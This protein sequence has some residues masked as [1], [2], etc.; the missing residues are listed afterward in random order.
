MGIVNYLKAV[1]E[2]I[3]AATFIV[4]ELLAIGMIVA[5][6]IA[7][8]ALPEWLPT[9]LAL[10]A[11]TLGNYLINLLLVVVGKTAAVIKTSD[12][13]TSDV[14]KLRDKVNQS[15]Y[16]N[17]LKEFANNSPFTGTLG[18]LY[19]LAEPGTRTIYGITKKEYLSLLRQALHDCKRSY[20]TV[21]RKGG[22][23][24]FNEDEN[25]LTEFKNKQLLTKQRILVAESMRVISKA[26]ASDAPLRYYWHAVGKD[27]NTHWITKHHLGELEI[28]APASQHGV[29][30][31]I[32]NGCDI[33]VCDD[34]L[35]IQY[36]E[37]QHKLEFVHSVHDMGIIEPYGWIFDGPSRYPTKFKL[38]MQPP[39]G[40]PSYLEFRNAKGIQILPDL[41]R[42]NVELVEGKILS[43]PR[44]IMA[45]LKCDAYGLGIDAVFDALRDAGVRWFGVSRVE[46]G[47]QILRLKQIREGRPN[48]VAEPLRIVL[49]EGIRDYETTE[50][51]RLG[52]EPFVWTEGDIHRLAMSARAIGRPARVHMKL[53][54]GMRV[55][56][57]NS[58][59]PNLVSAEVQDFVS[60]LH[61]H[62]PHVQ[63]AGVATQLRDGADQTVVDSQ[64][65]A[66]VT[67]LN[68]IKSA[69]PN[70]LESAWDEDAIETNIVLHLRNT[71]AVINGSTLNSQFD[72]ADLVRIG[73]AIYGAASGT[74]L[75]VR[76]V[77]EVS[78]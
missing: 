41:I 4:P 30:L 22:V 6:E 49:L 47:E 10:G 34:Q 77:G 27:M 60:L 54:T 26:H 14:G 74:D 8:T 39:E 7:E 76:V 37:D 21:H 67:S 36:Y 46:E 11:I 42:R 58:I 66:M 32:K 25:F 71:S 35:V 1:L 17:V 43:N 73:G 29:A 61:S 59:S 68:H 19:S 33:V 5:L 72:K 12:S 64:D 50:V 65:A 63:L 57:V 24:W 15:Y 69:F 16:S 48:S 44:R 3:K 78:E 13:L 9:W 55:V 20:K 75:P 53:D 18:T 40:L 38:L 23:D 2:P 56:G 52:L 70:V 62:K 31:P 51:V 28:Q 45:V